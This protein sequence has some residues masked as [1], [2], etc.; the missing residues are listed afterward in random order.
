MIKIQNLFHS[1]PRRYRHY[2]FLIFIICLIIFLLYIRH[3]SRLHVENIT[4]NDNNKFD[5]F[6]DDDRFLNCPPGIQFNKSNRHHLAIFVGPQLVSFLW[7]NFRALLCTGVDAYVM[8]NEVFDINSSS[9]G[10]GFPEH[11]NRSIRS[12]TH[13]FLHISDQILAKYGVSYMT[14]YPRVKYASWDRAIVWLYHRKYFQN[15][16]MI[17]YNVQWFHVQNITDFLNLYNSDRTDILCA[18]IVPTNSEFWQQWPKKQ[19]DIFPKSYWM[20]TFSPLVRW[21]RRLLLHHYQYMQLMHENRLKYEIN[22]DFRFQ[23]FLMGTIANIE[24]LS[25]ALYNQK[26]QFTHIRLGH[27]NDTDILI[28]LQRGKHIIYPIRYESILTKYRT[29]EIVEMMRK[30]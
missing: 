16:W 19:S 7:K 24:K 23:E 9:R 28:L 26:Y 30:I 10:D 15:V 12:Y 14:K 5:L 13:R 17:D 20:G 29:E 3:S 22:Q 4:N 18:D 21:S 8:L 27:Y 2:P 11:T 25:I 6:D 1:I